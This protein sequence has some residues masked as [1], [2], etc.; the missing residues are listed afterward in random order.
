M[1][2]RDETFLTTD[3]LENG[4]QFAA[5]QL[6]AIGVVHK[7]VAIACDAAA[8]ILVIKQ[9]DYMVGK[10]ASGIAHK[11]FPTLFCTKNTGPPGI[12]IFINIATTISTGHKKNRPMNETTRSKRNFTT[13]YYYKILYQIF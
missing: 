12:F 4:F 8:Q 3:T 5:G 11:H 1:F 7:G 6:P 10:F 13:I 2:L 9:P